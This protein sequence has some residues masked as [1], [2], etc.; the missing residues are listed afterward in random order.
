MLLELRT[1]PIL[2]RV[3]P[4]TPEVVAARQDGGVEHPLSPD[5]VL[6]PKA[7][8]GVLLKRGVRKQCPRCGGGHLFQTWFRMRARCPSC[9]YKFEREDG[10][11]LGAWYVNF[12]VTEG[13]VFVL[14]MLFVF[15]KDV[16]GNTSVVPIVV[17][18]VAVSTI[19]PILFYPFSRTIWAAIDLAMSPLEL[20]EIVAAQDAVHEGDGEAD[21]PDRGPAPQP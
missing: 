4:E 15:L 10:F 9:G 17:A 1:V 21:R 2:M 19:V 13:L 3:I 6:A 20:A 8:T 5:D 12:T 14:V 16:D 18:G 7:T 11:F